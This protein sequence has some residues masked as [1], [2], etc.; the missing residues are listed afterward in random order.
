MER[1]ALREGLKNTGLMGLI[2]KSSRRRRRRNKEKWIFKP[3]F[4]EHK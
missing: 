3:Q 2:N 4:S 1:P